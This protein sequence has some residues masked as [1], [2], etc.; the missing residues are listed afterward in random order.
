MLHIVLY[1]V[2]ME[3][4]TQTKVPRLRPR[5]P[6]LSPEEESRLI[7]DY[8]ARELTIEQI[9]KKYGIHPRTV[10]NIVSRYRE[11]EASA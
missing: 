6:K 8:A 2:R 4:N 3:R 1:I 9:A 7:A 5:R 11:A 10:N